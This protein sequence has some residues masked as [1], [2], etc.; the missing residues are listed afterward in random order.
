MSD[1]QLALEAA[2]QDARKI[3]DNYDKEI[4]R[5]QREKSDLRSAH[6][7]FKA[8]YA[9]ELVNHKAEMTESNQRIQSVQSA[10]EAARQDAR[11]VKDDYD[12]EVVCLQGEKSDL[13]SA[14][15]ALR[16]EMAGQKQRLSPGIGD[17]KKWLRESSVGANTVLD[18]SS[19]PGDIHHVFA[20]NALV[21]V[22]SENW[23][24]AC[25]DAKQVILHILTRAF[26]L[27]R[28]HVKSIIARTSSMGYTAKALAQIGKGEPED[29]MQVL[30]LAFRNC[31]P[32]ESHLLLLVKVCSSNPWQVSDKQ[33]LVMSPRLSCCLYPGIMMSRFRAFAI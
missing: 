21:K 18:P 9:I 4:A 32:N 17:F 28:S 15:T 29:A 10:L 1:L 27:N 23:I 5:L 8:R 30:D 13:Q 22:R 25:E 16:A 7:A 6:D 26:V 11:K 31:N 14:L 12:K 3:K 2:R 19:S 24:E 33:L 20:H